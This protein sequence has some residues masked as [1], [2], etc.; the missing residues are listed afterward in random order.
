M[1]NPAWQL[2]LPPPP[3][4][5]E[6]EDAPDDDE[7]ENRF[8]FKSSINGLIAGDHADHTDPVV[9]Q[10]SREVYSLLLGRLNAIS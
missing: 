2:L 5:E 8:I 7:I 4:H 3:R 10:A 6:D 9:M 1:L